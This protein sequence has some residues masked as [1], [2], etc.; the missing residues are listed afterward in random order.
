M[1][2]A[3]VRK[4]SRGAHARDDYKDRDDENWQKHTMSYIKDVETGKVDLKYRSV[5][6]ETLDQN[7]FPTVPNAKRVY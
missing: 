1:V 6:M 5:I 2:S 3:S 7:E 4:E